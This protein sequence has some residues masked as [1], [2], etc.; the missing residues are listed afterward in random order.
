MKAGSGLP[1]FPVEVAEIINTLKYCNMMQYCIDSLKCCVNILS[2]VGDSSFVL[3]LNLSPL[4]IHFLTKIMLYS[5][6]GFYQ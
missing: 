2:I 5:N 3:Y 4:V 6:H 1:L